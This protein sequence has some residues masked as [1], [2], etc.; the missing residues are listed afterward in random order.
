MTSWPID[1]HGERSSLGVEKTE[2]SPRHE[3]HRD[4]SLSTKEEENLSEKKLLG[5]DGGKSFS[6]WVGALMSSPP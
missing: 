6:P 1:T 2:P 3:I 5:G 4:L